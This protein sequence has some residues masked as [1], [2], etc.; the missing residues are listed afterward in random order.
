MSVPLAFI[1]VILIW[2]TTP[3]AIKWSS[4]GGGFLFGVASRMILGTLVCLVILRLLKQ[5]L[6]WHRGA[7]TTYVAAGIGVY[8]GMLSVY[9][10]AQYIPSGLISV[11][12]GLTPLA[13]GLLAALWLEDE[14]FGIERLLGSVFGIF[15]LAI[16]FTTDFDTQHIAIQGIFAVLLSVLLHSISSVRVK[17]SA[18]GLSPL[19]ITTGGL[20]IATPLYIITW[21]IAEGLSMPAQLTPRAGLAILYLGTVGSVVGFMLY[22]YML[23]HVSAGRVA[24]VTLVTPVIALLLGSW[25]NNENPGQQILYGT[26]LILCGLL[27]Y[28]WRE[29]RSLV[30]PANQV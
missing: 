19:A 1:S 11:I 10:G 8:G 9:W 22:F 7:L 15:G 13:T 18:Q 2:S 24:L 23:R 3:L 25:L 28:Q 30:K 14:P 26:A 21:L 16:I 29:I 4:E 20:L 27:I 12:F 5:R 17:A 6:P